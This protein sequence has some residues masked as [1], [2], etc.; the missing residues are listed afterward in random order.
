[1]KYAVIKV[2]NGNYAVHAETDTLNS[3]VVNYH[4]LCSTLWN[5]PDVLSATVSIVDEFLAVQKG[6]CEHI[7]HDSESGN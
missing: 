1:M 3:A 4:S 2:I 7:Y 5:T 6:Y